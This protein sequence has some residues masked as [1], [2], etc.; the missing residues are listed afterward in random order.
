MIKLSI[1]DADMKNPAV[2]AAVLAL[3]GAL[4]PARGRPGRR[5]AAEKDGGGGNGR[6]APRAAKAKLGR[7]RGRLLNEREWGAF[8]KKL[9]PHQRKFLDFVKKR[10]TATSA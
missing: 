5:P 9:R 8:V 10:G 1:S 7:P 2:R 6:R 4:S 3:I